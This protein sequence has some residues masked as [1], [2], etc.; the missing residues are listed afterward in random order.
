MDISRVPQPARLDMLAPEILLEIFQYFALHIARQSYSEPHNVITL[1]QLRLTCRALEPF[2]STVLFS[3]IE[4]ALF[5]ATLDN[6]TRIIRSPRLHGYVRTIAWNNLMFE[7]AAARRYRHYPGDLVSER[8]DIGSRITCEWI[9]DKHNIQNSDKDY[10]LLCE[11]L[12]CLPKLQ[13]LRIDFFTPKTWMDSLRPEVVR[14]A[15]LQHS[16]PEE[17]QHWFLRSGD[18]RGSARPCWEDFSRNDKS[19]PHRN[20]LMFLRVLSA[21]RCS[22]ERLG[23]A[24]DMNMTCTA[25]FAGDD[26]FVRHIAETFGGIRHL[27]IRMSDKC[28]ASH[29]SRGYRL[30]EAL[31]LNK[32]LRS[33]DLYYKNRDCSGFDLA[34][35][36]PSIIQWASLR[37]LSLC[38]LTCKQDQLETLLLHLR[39]TLRKVRFQWMTLKQGSW[40]HLIDQMQKENYRL[41]A[42]VLDRVWDNEEL[43]LESYG[44][45]RISA[46]SAMLLPYIQQGAKRVVLEYSEAP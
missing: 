16:I 44:L 15:N 22:V 9:Q 32:N 28:R 29:L 13:K 8:S 18:C 41:V 33:F 26:E 1:K 4:M 39:P 7:D 45:G 21:E 40:Q 11:A 42:F 10:N 31:A 20:F 30:Y 5:H 25:C 2:A 36:R 27:S 38:R 14:A 46:G 37:D 34:I 17:E 19:S 12:R 35:P 6:F 43:Q 3:E 23:L 24:L